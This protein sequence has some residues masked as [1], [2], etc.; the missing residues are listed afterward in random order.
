MQ[1]CRGDQQGE[2]HFPLHVSLLRAARTAVKPEPAPVYLKVKVSEGQWRSN[3]VVQRTDAQLPLSRVRVYRWE[4][5]L[6]ES[7]PVPCQGLSPRKVNEKRG[8]FADCPPD[9]TWCY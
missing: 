8:L 6:W 3:V 5:H 4:S 2:I 9:N 7:S 1:D